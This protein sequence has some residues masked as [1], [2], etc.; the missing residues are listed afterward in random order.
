M[1]FESF[2]GKQYLKIDIASNFG[3]DKA[4]WQERL[5]WFDKHEDQLLNMVNQAEEPALFYAG[6]KAWEKVKA[7]EP[8]GYMISLDATSSGLQLLACLTGDDKAA[9]IC[10]VIDTG[11]REDAYT[12]VYQWMCEK[13]ND[14]QKIKR[15]DTKQAIMTS[16]YGSQAVPKTVF[17]EGPLLL[18]F[19]E[20]M[21]TMAPAAWELNEAFLAM[22]NSKVSVYGWVLPDNFTVQIKV[23]DTVREYVNFLN[24][25]FEVIFKEQRP[26]ENGRALGANS[27]HSLDGMVVREMTRR[28]FYNADTIEKL[29]SLLDEDISSEPVESE[30]TENDKL[31]GTLWSHYINSGFLSARILDVLDANNLRQVDRT[32]IRELIDSLPEKPF[33]VISIHDCFRCHPNYGNDLRRQYNNLLAL[34]AKSDLLGFLVSQIMGQPIKVKKQKIDL[35]KDIYESNYALS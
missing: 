21:K 17:G 26:I 7:G 24:E 3:L 6:V 12:R 13:I 22:W 19:H 11:K 31:V 5:D 10:N 16:L 20:A 30:P 14:S 2:T 35:Y 4:L 18:I 1:T 25:P 34:I 29:K 9:S 15:E 33:E 27:T 32:I 8:I 28:C 23:M